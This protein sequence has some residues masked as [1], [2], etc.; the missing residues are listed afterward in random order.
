LPGRTQ[1]RAQLVATDRC[2]RRSRGSLTDKALD[3]A[4]MTPVPQGRGASCQRNGATARTHENGQL[5]APTCG[6]VPIAVARTGW[7]SAAIEHKEH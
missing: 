3:I 5:A 1:V 6:P 7:E 4:G 2:L